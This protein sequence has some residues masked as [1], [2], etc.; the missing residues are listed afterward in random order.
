MTEASSPIPPQ[1]LSWTPVTKAP[2]PFLREER[3]RLSGQVAWTLAGNVTYAACQWGMLIALAKLV[4]PEMVGQ[5]GLGLAISTPIIT[6]TNLQ[7]RSIQ[8][9]Q[10]SA[11]YKLSDYLSVRILSSFAALLAIALVVIG[12]SYRAASASV[13]LVIGVAKC[14]ESISDTLYGHLQRNERMDQIAK[15]MIAKGLVS[16]LFLVAAVAITRE[17]LYGVGALALAWLSVLLVYDVPHAARASLLRDDLTPMRLVPRWKRLVSVARLGLPLGITSVCLALSSNVPR[18]FLERA[19]GETALGYFAALIF[20]TAAF[21]ILLSGV[22]QA[23]TPRMADFYAGAPKKYLRLVLALSAIPLIVVPV[24]LLAVLSMGPHVLAML[25]RADYSSHFGVFV[26]LIV[27]AGVWSLASVL[28]YAATA[29]HRVIGQAPAAVV[30]LIVAAIASWLLI[31][32]YGIQGAALVNV[33]SGSVAVVAYA[34]LLLPARVWKV[35]RPFWGRQ[36][37][38]GDPG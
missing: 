32:Q 30:T 20:P 23:A 29:A 1:I 19:R 18:F 37:Y 38:G 15:S 22:G 2:P 28:G 10:L 24:I 11:R 4:S 9:T 6:L 12:S 34:V 5:F 17:V 31:P 33:I 13:V 21:S 26:L 27:G 16:L 14:I 36:A 7:L 3:P 35:P 25:Y 8:A